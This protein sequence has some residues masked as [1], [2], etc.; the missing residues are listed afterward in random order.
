MK[1]EPA[2]PVPIE[3]K[4]R[5]NTHAL[6]HREHLVSRG[7]RAAAAHI[8]WAVSSLASGIG[9]AVQTAAN[10]GGAAVNMAAGN[11]SSRPLTAEELREE[12]RLKNENN[13]T[14]F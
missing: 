11:V 3:P 8:P 10:V 5:V 7:I 1:S 2:V 9:T 14:K 13:E 12:Q 4:R 6:R